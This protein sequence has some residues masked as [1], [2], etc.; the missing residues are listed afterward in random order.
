MR[1][2]EEILAEIESEEGPEPTATVSGELAQVA[3]AMMQVAAAEQALDAAVASAREAGNSW[4]AIGE[5]LGMTRQGALKR[6]RA[7]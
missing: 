6:F 4:Q 7:A 1:T 2:D 3:V 5:V